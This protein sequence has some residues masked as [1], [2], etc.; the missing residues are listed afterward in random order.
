MGAKTDVVRMSGTVVRQLPNATFQVK[1]DEGGHE[2]LAR[3][4][5]R[6]R[7]GRRIRIVPGDRVEVEVSLY[8]PTRGRIVWRYR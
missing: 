5:G 4:A 8:D 3:A 7:R 6:L 1:L 2:V